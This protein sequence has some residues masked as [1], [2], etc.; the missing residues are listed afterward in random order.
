MEKWRRG[1][2]TCLQEWW[3]FSRFGGIGVSFE[4][5]IGFHSSLRFIVHKA[6]EG[7]KVYELPKGLT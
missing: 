1:G 2:I 5:Q 3:G 4:D 7:A 6:Q